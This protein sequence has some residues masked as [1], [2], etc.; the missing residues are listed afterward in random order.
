MA[1]YILIDRSSGY[2]FG[3]TADYLGGRDPSSIT[4]AAR[5]LD[6]SIG[7][8]GRD[9]EELPRAE[10]EGR[11]LTGYDVYRADIDGSEAVAAIQDGQDQE[12]IEAVERDCQY[13]G[14]VACHSA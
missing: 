11:T 4:E 3:D 13:A 2:I 9:Y 7:E 8:R 10:H 1:R 6:E 14:F 5:L 12:T